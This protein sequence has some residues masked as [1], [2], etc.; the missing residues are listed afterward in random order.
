MNVCVCACVVQ[1]SEKK[2]GLFEKGEFQPAEVLNQG[3]R[4]LRW[5]SL[6]KWLQLVKYNDNY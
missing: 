6:F 2:I 4:D 5:K 3:L 1:N